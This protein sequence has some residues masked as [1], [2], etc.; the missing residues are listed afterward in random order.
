MLFPAWA[1]R[2]GDYITFVDAHDPVPRRVVKTTYT[3]D[4]KTCQLDL[5]SPP[6]ALQALLARLAGAVAPLGF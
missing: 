2:G 1:I 5:D 3:D 6:Q 4:T